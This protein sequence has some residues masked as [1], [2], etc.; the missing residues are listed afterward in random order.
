MKISKHAERIK[1]ACNLYVILKFSEGRQWHCNKTENFETAWLLRENCYKFR[2]YLKLLMYQFVLHKK[3][4][5][6]WKFNS[7]FMKIITNMYGDS[8]K[9]YHSEIVG[10]KWE[11]FY[12]NTF[13]FAILSFIQNINCF[14]FF[15]HKYTILWQ[16][17]WS[18]SIKI[19][20]LA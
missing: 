12:Y 19:N 11:S 2:R 18:K 1:S 10:I 13:L 17:C 8:F 14:W 20:K 6:L 7:K 4:R 9:K 15:M 5:L 3:A 16:I